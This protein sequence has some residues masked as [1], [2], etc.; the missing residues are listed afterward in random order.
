M[1]LSVWYCS[2]FSLGI[3]PARLHCLHLNYIHLYLFISLCRVHLPIIWLGFHTDHADLPWTIHNSLIYLLALLSF[4]KI[5][6]LLLCK[7]FIFLTWASH[8]LFS[9]PE[10]R[11][12]YVIALYIA[13]FVLL[14][15]TTRC[16]LFFEKYFI[17]SLTLN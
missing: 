6:I 16:L 15:W 2:H 17:Y 8:Y 11:L 13:L 5:L 12:I 14:P 10:Q 1:G 9:C 7:L 3:N 4:C